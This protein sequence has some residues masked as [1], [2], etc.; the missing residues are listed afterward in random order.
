MIG[1]DV[2]VGTMLWCFDTIGLPS[3]VKLTGYRTI[4]VR[5]YGLAAACDSGSPHVCTTLDEFYLNEKEA[6]AECEKYLL[7]ALA[8][9]LVDH[10]V[11]HARLEACKRVLA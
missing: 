10:E 11:I 3:L 9:N 6:F 8:Q 2:P 5:T 1:T 7:R 4:G